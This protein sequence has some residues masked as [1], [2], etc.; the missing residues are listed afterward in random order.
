MDFARFVKFRTS[1][2]IRPAAQL[3]AIM[4]DHFNS[5]PTEG[6]GERSMKRLAEAG[7]E[8]GIL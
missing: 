1:I 7:D 4:I 8:G 2:W 3:L 5:D 6:E